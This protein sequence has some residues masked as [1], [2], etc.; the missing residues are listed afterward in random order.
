M[1]HAGNTHEKN[2]AKRKELFSFFIAS[3]LQIDTA[4]EAD[5]L[6]RKVLGNDF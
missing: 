4:H 2:T 1:K 3:R 5:I 6:N